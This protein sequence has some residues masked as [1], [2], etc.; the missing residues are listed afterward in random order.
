MKS[1][2]TAPTLKACAI[3]VVA[4][5]LSAP[6][7]VSGA[8]NPLTPGTFGT[9][10]EQCQTYSGISL[11][12]LGGS[13]TGVAH[14]ECTVQATR[15]V[16][17][18]NI[19]K[20]F[21]Q[22]EACTEGKAE[23]RAWSVATAIATVHANSLVSIDCTETH[24]KAKGCG[25]GV[26]NG[27]ALAIAWTEAIAFAAAGAI[28]DGK[29]AF[30]QSDIGALIPVLAHAFARS[31]TQLCAVATG[32]VSLSAFQNSFFQS[33]ATAMADAFATASARVCGKLAEAEC[34]GEAGSAG[35]SSSNSG[36]GISGGVNTDENSDGSSAGTV[37]GGANG[38][39][40]STCG[41][42][43]VCCD[44][45]SYPCNCPGCPQSLA[46]FVEFDLDNPGGPKK[47]IKSGS[48]FCFCPISANP[49]GR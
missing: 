46:E 14:A 34:T 29:T 24:A 6:H 5:A 13:C 47:I 32:P 38:P 35:P 7:T 23:A 18:Q 37:G 27:D 40:D 21:F 2:R 41:A 44:V 31:H 49:F 4:I 3:L 42:M 28:D 48:K 20:T 8:G 10:L 11:T 39:F 43:S 30:C 15:L 45:A 36:G 9:E 16:E 25:F 26:G 1:A 22:T 12:V 19:V 33:S 17:V